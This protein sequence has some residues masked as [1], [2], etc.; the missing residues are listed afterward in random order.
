MAI[1]IVIFHASFTKN[2]DYIIQGGC[3]VWIMHFSLFLQHIKTCGYNITTCFAV[4][5]A[6]DI[7]ITRGAI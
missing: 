7:S 1:A 6:A 2:T 3:V 4:I 5:T